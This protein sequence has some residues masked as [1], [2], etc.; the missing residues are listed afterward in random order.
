MNLRP[1]QT[2]SPENLLALKQAAK[3]RY[4]TEGNT[5]ILQD[6]F[7]LKNNDVNSFIFFPID[8]LDST[9]P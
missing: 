1:G 7:A 4:G 3:T 5:D 9:H 2:E 8:F 6:I